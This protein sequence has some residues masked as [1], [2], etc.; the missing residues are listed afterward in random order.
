MLIETF[1]SF[2]LGY[3]KICRIVPNDLWFGTP[4]V[5][6]LRHLDLLNRTIKSQVVNK[7]VQINYHHETDQHARRMR[8]PCHMHS[9]M[10]TDCMNRGIYALFLVVTTGYIPTGCKPKKYHIC[11]DKNI[12]RSNDW[13]PT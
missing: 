9:A 11:D 8:Q 7:P 13:Y 5:Y 10:A 4:A 1:L 2:I 3:L 6:R 12:T